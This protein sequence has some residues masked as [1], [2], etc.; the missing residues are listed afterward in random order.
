MLIVP[1]SDMTLYCMQMMGARY[2]STGIRKGMEFHRNAAPTYGYIFN[3]AGA[4]S[5]LEIFPGQSREDWSNCSKNKL[6]L[7]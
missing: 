7:C 6:E 5:L 2:L 1:K 3:Y 4:R